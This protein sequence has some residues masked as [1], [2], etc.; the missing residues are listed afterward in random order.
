VKSIASI[1]NPLGLFSPVPLMGK[2]FMQTLWNKKFE[3]DFKLSEEDC[4][5]WQGIAKDIQ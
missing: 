3:W 2:H 1:F 4:K 5:I